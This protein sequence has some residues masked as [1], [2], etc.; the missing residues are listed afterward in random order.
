MNAQVAANLFYFLLTAFA[1][2][3]IRLG[4]F[5][6]KVIQRLLSF[7]CTLL[8]TFSCNTG[9]EFSFSS[10]LNPVSHKKNKCGKKYSTQQTIKEV[11]IMME[12][13]TQSKTV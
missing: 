11:Q 8:V 4:I 7:S 5:H 1:C 6:R 13:K 2:T 12:M 10:Q 9:I 3:A